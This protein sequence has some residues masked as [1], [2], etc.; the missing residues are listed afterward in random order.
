MYF[1]N[2]ANPATPYYPALKC[3]KLHLRCYFHRSLT[4]HHRWICQ[5]ELSHSHIWSF[6]SITDGHDLTA[7]VVVEAPSNNVPSWLKI[8]LTNKNVC[9][10]LKYKITRFLVFYYI[11]NFFKLSKSYSDPATKCNLFVSYI[12]GKIHTRPNIP[13]RQSSGVIGL[14]MKC[15]KDRGDCSVKSKTYIWLCTTFT[16]CVSFKKLPFHTFCIINL[17]SQTAQ[18]YARVTLSTNLR[19]RAV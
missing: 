12:S 8:R 19:N 14:T 7:R 16:F 15:D 3:F 4:L 1:K 18:F 2:A 17:T 9:S 10:H 6:W 5:C 11:Y 13:V